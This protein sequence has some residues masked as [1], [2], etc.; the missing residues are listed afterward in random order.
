MGIP[1]TK[2]SIKN[3]NF[4]GKVN[5]AFFKDYIKTLLLLGMPEK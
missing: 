3:S 1:I 5:D 4:V 2:E